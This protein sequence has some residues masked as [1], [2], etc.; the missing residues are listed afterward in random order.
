M[1]KWLQMHWCRCRRRR[2][3]R[4][5][6]RCLRPCRRH[7]PTWYAKL[8]LF[9]ASICLSVFRISPATRE[10]W[11]WCS[12][13]NRSWCSLQQNLG[14]EITGR[15]EGFGIL[16]SNFHVQFLNSAFSATKEKTTKP[17]T[18]V[19]AAS[20]HSMLHR[21]QTVQPDNALHVLPY[22]P[23][24]FVK[25]CLWNPRKKIKNWKRNRNRKNNSTDIKT[26]KASKDVLWFQGSSFCCASSFSC[27]SFGTSLIVSHSSWPAP[28]NSLKSQVY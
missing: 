14:T 4:H 27:V 21:L 22:Q 7:Y 16:R 26:L 12:C 11:G 13:A 3:R 15:V 8:C 10:S 9:F 2:R 5:H 23:I 19:V 20:H 25:D 18:H 17:A 6:H 24:S 28:G 1:D